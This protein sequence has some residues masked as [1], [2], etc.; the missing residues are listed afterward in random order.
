[1]FKQTKTLLLLLL[2]LNLTITVQASEK[3]LVNPSGNISI[4][5]VT[6][7]VKSQNLAIQAAL[8]NVQAKNQLI[9]QAGVLPNP[10]IE[11]ES[12]NILGSGGNKGFDNA[13]TTA[14]L[15]T[16]IELGGKRHYRIKAAELTKNLAELN[17]LSVLSSMVN[18]AHQLSV[19]VMKQ[20]DLL[21]LDKERSK[22]NQ[23]FLDE[24]KVRVQKGRLN[25]VEQKRANIL[26]SQ[27][28]L[29]IKKRRQ[30]L[31]NSKNLLSLTWGQPNAEFETLQGNVQKL[32]PLQSL[33]L[34]QKQLD[35]YVVLQVKR[36]EVELSKV[37]IELEKS[38]GSQDL[39]ISGGLK[40][41]NNNNDK[42]FVL[43]AGIPIAI[44][45]RNTGAIEAARLTLKKKELEL[46]RAFIE[47]RS[48]LERL[49]RH[50][51]LLET[52][53]N[54]LKKEI[55]PQSKEVFAT[56]QDG[57]LKGKFSYL[58][59]LESQNTLFEFRETHIDTLAQYHNLT[60]EIKLLTGSILKGESNETNI[61]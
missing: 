16:L 40:H 15:G 59:V 44:F 60:L 7:I 29:A 41:Q 46:E 51:E 58:E 11:L 10:E 48:N 53:I 19:D 22:T 56:L 32:T 57:Y 24:I 39:S 35:E 45:D 20:Q 2:F 30:A 52:E 3:A 49:Y 54:S 5:Q 14:K 13:E 1:M 18:Q 4:E 9:K 28:K 42:S 55:I 37:E 43:S 8:K 61:N 27:S 17:Y 47:T 33:D 6:K 25:I 23:A 21:E 26:V 34:L 50:A 38:K 31:N 36:N 12:E